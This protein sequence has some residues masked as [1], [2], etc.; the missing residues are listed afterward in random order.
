MRAQSF[1]AV[2]FDMDG[3]VVDTERTVSEFWL[4]LAR[5]EGT[6]LTPADL[7]EH[8]FGRPAAHTLSALFP[9]IPESRYR[10]V[11]EKLEADNRNLRYTEIPGASTLLHGLKGN[12]I[13]M[14]LVTGA[15]HWKVTEVISQL[16]L[17]AVFD[18]TVGAED[19][20]AGKPDPQCYLLAAA[21]LGA[22]TDRCLVFE[23]AISGIAA[24]VAAGAACVALAPER[25][26][27]QALNAGAVAVVAD[28]REVRFSAG[29]GQ[30]RVGSRL[31]FPFAQR[32]GRLVP[33]RHA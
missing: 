22:R 21:R 1:D 32:R 13:P 33:A 14:A 28:L 24:A 10:N 11:Y 4:E 18:T 30:M 19:I 9:M 6:S 15:Q 31:V 20:A 17:A 7:E 8:V 3:V 27:K 12:R 29:T 23:D 25:R 26:R 16:K 2:L 5:A